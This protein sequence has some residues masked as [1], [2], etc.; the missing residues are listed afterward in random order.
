MWNNIPSSPEGNLLRRVDDTHPL[1]LFIGFDEENRMM[2]VLFTDHLPKFCKSSKEILVR[3]IFRE[4]KIYVARFSLTDNIFKDVFITL[5]W[6]ILN[7]TY[8]V[9]DIRRGITMLLDRFSMWQKL[10]EQSKAA[11]NEVKGLIGELLVLRDYC[12][13]KF[14]ISASINAWGGPFGTD[15]DFEYENAWIEVKTISLSAH[16]IQISSLEQLDTMADGLLVVCRL[17]KSSIIAPETIT[18]QRLIL[19]LESALVTEPDALH[20]L[21]TMIQLTGYDEHDDEY[22]PAFSFHRFETYRVT[23]DFPR[24]RRTDVPREVVGG[25]YFINIPMIQNWREE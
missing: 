14:G 8:P 11:G 4:D 9:A 5:T 15:R 13:P 3:A 1:D 22:M 2:L 12:F 7:F 10:M 19:S 23:H 21:R 17:E 6:D 20:V 24:I 25:S 18:L 16:Q